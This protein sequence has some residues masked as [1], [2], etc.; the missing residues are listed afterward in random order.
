MRIT[1]MS[2]ATIHALNETKLDLARAYIEKQRHRR[3]SNKVLHGHPSPSFW[4]DRAVSVPEVLTQRR[5]TTRAIPKA[6]NV[7]V[8]SPY[9]LRTDPDRCGFCL[10]PSEVYEGRE[11]LDT[12]LDVLAREAAMYRPWLEGEKVANV[13][14]GG[15]TSNLYRAAQYGLLVDI[16]RRVFGGFG[17]SVEITLEGIPQL[18][19][20]EK[21]LAM[22]D[23]GI[24]RIS[25][26]VQQLDDALI[27]F[28]GRKQHAGQ[29]F[30]TL[31]WCDELGLPCSIDL[32]FGWPQQTVDHMVRD[33]EAAVR[34]GVAHLTHYELNVAGRTDF[35]RH[36]RDELPSPA[37][38]LEMYH[39]ARDFLVS[40]GYRQVTAYDW[41]RVERG[42]S[43]KLRYEDSWHAPF[44][45]NPDD[46]M[47]GHEA[48]G[49]GFAGTSFFLGSVEAPGHAYMNHTRV[50]DY[51]R[52]VA[53]GEFPVERGLR[54]AATDLRLTTL[55][56]MLHG[57]T[58]DL[59]LYR[60]LFG[61]DLV[62]EHA[63]IWQALDDCGWV[64]IRSDQLTLVGDG[65]F[66]T[67][68]I[69]GLLAQERMEELRRSR[70]RMELAETAA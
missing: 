57:M 2:P 70:P 69:Q 9:C 43:A 66:Y 39:I 27:K 26:G 36:R 12:Y 4:L 20:R 59:R 15:G 52:R 67:P 21:L 45:A 31:A 56:Q 55:F 24:N 18:Y 19:T 22:K 29:V 62:E 25:M 51:C 35:A 53:Q 6:L 8:G 41:E 7:Y 49:L 60:V 38:N 44:A 13:Y 47:T 42:D 68:L 61:V 48:F 37:Q 23:A 10:F 58:V 34:A 33:L 50:S 17:S 30:Q 1:A 40:H 54:Y 5:Q 32:I 3:Q 11:Q 63:E 65:V 46:G 28:S 64:E 14:F 16:A